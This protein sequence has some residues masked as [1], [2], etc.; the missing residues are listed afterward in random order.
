MRALVLA[1]LVIFQCSTLYAGPARI[2]TT[3]SPRQSEYLGVDW[4][5]A[6]LSTLETGFDLIRLGAYWDE[7]EKEEDV[8]DFSALDWQVRE[9]RKRKIPVVLTVGMKAPRWPEYYIP[10]WVL[11]KAAPPFGADVSKNTYLRKR[12]LKFVE[13][14]VNRYKNDPIIH[15][16]QVEN[17]PLNRIGQKYWFIGKAFLK[18]EVELVRKLDERERPILL[19]AA[20]YPGRISRFLDR[21]FVWHDS[22][23]ECLEMGDIL[24]LNVYPV[25]GERFWR[26]DLH[27]RTSRQEREKYFSKILARVKSRKKKAWV[28]ELQAEPWEPGQ[29]VYKGEKAASTCSPAMTAEIFKEFRE[30]GVDT[31]LLWGAEYWRFRKTR[32]GDARWQKAILNILRENAVINIYMKRQKRDDEK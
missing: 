4:K 1:V 29:L 15:W 12:T 22:I 23:G 9:A 20:T 32:Y 30:L 13:K 18:Q 14:V 16:W 31:I 19:T 10:D 6:Y 21:L 11:K 8:Y 28:T 2:G 17:E 7:I 24:G 26:I 27:F 25:V 3:Y 5:K